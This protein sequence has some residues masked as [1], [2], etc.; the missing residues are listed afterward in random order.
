MRA[1]A[2]SAL[3][4]LC[5]MPRIVVAALSNITAASRATSRVHAHL[6]RAAQW[7]AGVSACAWFFSGAPSLRRRMLARRAP[8]ALVFVPA[9]RLVLLLPPGCRQHFERV[10]FHL[11]RGDEGR[12]VAGIFKIWSGEKAIVC[13]RHRRNNTALQTTAFETPGVMV[14]VEMCRMRGL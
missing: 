9:V 5:F 4:L 11:S 3:V 1:A 7:R 6:L 14:A 12:G 10:H 8:R 2:W 13:L